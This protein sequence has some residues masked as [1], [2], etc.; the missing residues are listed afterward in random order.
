M[1]CTFLA[2][3]IFIMLISNNLFACALD[4]S[5]GIAPDNK[6]KI[7]V[8]LK[9]SSVFQSAVQ[10]DYLLQKLYDHFSPFVESFG[11]QLQLFN[12]WNVED[13]NAI[14]SRPTSN[15]YRINIFGGLTRFPNMTSDALVLVF[16]HELGHHIGGAPIKS[17]DW[18]SSEGQSDYW[19]AMKCFRE[20]VK[21][22][23]S[24]VE[25]NRIINSYGKISS[26]LLDKC[27]KQYSDNYEKKICLR[28]GLAGKSL[29][30]ILNVMSNNSNTVD[31]STPNLYETPKNIDTHPEAQCRLDTYFSASLCP[32]DIFNISS[33]QSSTTGFCTEEYGYSIGFRPHCW[34]A[35]GPKVE[36][37]PDSHTKEITYDEGKI[38]ASD[39]MTNY[40]MNLING[41]KN[42]LFNSFEFPIDN[43]FGDLN[44]DK[45]SFDKELKN[46]FSKWSSRR[47]E[48]IEISFD[49]N[50]SNVNFYTVRL[51]YKYEFKN[52]E[53]K[54]FSGTSINFIK[55][56]YL[57][58]KFTISSIYEYVE[59]DSDGRTS[60]ENPPSMSTA[61]YNSKA[62]LSLYFDKLVDGDDLS[63][64][65]K[66]YD[67]PIKN[68]FGDKNISSEDFD[69]QIIN[70]Y[71]K[72]K[73]R[74]AWITELSID[75]GKST[76]SKIF[77]TLKYRYEFLSVED[78]IFKGNSKNT[79]ILEW[80]GN[81]FYI[82]SIDEKVSKDWF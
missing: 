80:I 67:F 4:G 47:G 37:Q 38:K 55:L 15:I 11:A 60:Q 70:Y 71:K 13:V 6:F 27:S 39:F 74:K 22:V 73:N 34:Y 2:L 65:K 43:Y 8:G 29:A 28:T 72:W 25:T 7:P 36:N 3:I 41:D 77:A 62:I 63:L 20:Y 54:L 68:Y 32:K 16:C 46:Y 79:I 81:K 33:S 56:K 10:V 31:F 5:S 50:K 17:N 78:K 49:D 14:A 35:P 40:Y 30:Q 57:N 53:G 9:S 42:E 26:I 21:E 58:N 64:L 24:E 51:I 44:F 12:D 69:N 59:R 75:E 82:T 18:A 52:L 61:I 66:F 45:N 1:K 76:N 19:G 48:L 23:S